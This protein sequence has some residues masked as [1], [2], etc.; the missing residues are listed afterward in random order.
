MPKEGPSSGRQATASN[1]NPDVQL[2]LLQG[3]ECTVLESPAGKV[4]AHEGKRRGSPG[5]QV[6]VDDIAG[7]KVV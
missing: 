3:A 5:F 2:G 4:K 7:V 1:D 6:K